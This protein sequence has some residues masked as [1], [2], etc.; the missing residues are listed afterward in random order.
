[1]SF[2]KSIAKQLGP[3]ASGS[4]ILTP[5]QVAGGATMDADGP[6]SR[7]CD[8]NRELLKQMRRGRRV[9]V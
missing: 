8:S 6:S 7:S 5:L 2:T 9:E 1:M 4:P 3:E